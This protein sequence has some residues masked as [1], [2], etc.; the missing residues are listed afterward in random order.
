MITLTSSTGRITSPDTT[1]R[2][3]YDDNVDVL[4]IIEA[5]DGQIIQFHLVFTQIR[6]SPD[7]TDD[8]LRVSGFYSLAYYEPRCEK[9]GLR[10]FRPGPTQT[11]LQDARGFALSTCSENKALIS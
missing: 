3:L 4:W 10:G 7:C 6:D 8:G 2:G 5:P 1:D 11:G 9:T